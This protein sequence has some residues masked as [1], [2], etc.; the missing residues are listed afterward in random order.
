MQVFSVFFHPSAAF[1]A[2]G[3]AEKRLIRVLEHW[4]SQQVSITVVDSNPGLLSSEYGKREVFGIQ[5]PI[6]AS[7]KGLFSIYLEWVLWVLKAC[8][9]CPSLVKRRRYD[10]ILASSNTLPNLIVAYLLH[11]TSKVSLCVV[12]HHMDFPYID[13]QATLLSVYSEYRKAQFNMLASSIKAVT[14]FLMLWLMRRSDCC[15]TVSKYTANVLLKNHVPQSK[16]KRS[17]NGIDINLI[18][19]I[20]VA[21]KQYDGVFIGRIARDKGI[22]DL[23]QAWKLISS[24]RLNSQLLILGSGPDFSELASVVKDSG[25]ASNIVL[26]GSCKDIDLYRLMKASRLLVFPSR[27]EG[28]GLA[29]GEALACGL[30]AVCYD[31]PALREVFGKCR[32]VFFVPVGDIA[33]L[34]E[35]AEE[36]LKYCDLSEL[37]KTSKEYVKGFSWNTI[38]SKDMQIL[39][40]LVQSARGRSG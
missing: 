33:R 7:G 10:C 26:K 35:T 16:V 5:S 25:I 6:H 38:A 29:V 32:S 4:A 21:A 37:E 20:K 34:A 1:T 15:I 28:W 24:N 36:I 8:F 18:E 11:R 12:V 39:K 31:I 22:F 17:G 2:L 3:G 13:R 14:F 9:L 19:S 23:V 30:P 27:F 40:E